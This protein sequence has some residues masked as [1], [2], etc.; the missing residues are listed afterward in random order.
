VLLH[1][2]YMHLGINP[3]ASLFDLNLCVHNTEVGM[4]HQMVPQK[5]MERLLVLAL[6][7]HLWY[8]V[9]IHPLLEAGNQ[10]KS[11]IW[12]CSHNIIESMIF[13]HIMSSSLCSLVSIIIPRCRDK[14]HSYNTS[15][16]EK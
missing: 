1:L 14:E 16:N 3:K 7:K 8:H 4:E 15:V 11:T 5:W 13:F 12:G 6:H 2:Y 10:V 9:V